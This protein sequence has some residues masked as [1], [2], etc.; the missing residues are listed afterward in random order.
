MCVATRWAVQHFI[1]MI[2][3]IWPRFFIFH[4]SLNEIPIGALTWHLNRCFYNKLI[5]CIYW[6]IYICWATCCTNLFTALCP[7]FHSQWVSP[8]FKPPYFRLQP[9]WAIQVNTVILLSFPNNPLKVNHVGS[10]LIAHTDTAITTHISSFCVFTN[11]G[12][13]FPQYTGLVKLCAVKE[14]P[15]PL[16]CTE[17]LLKRPLSVVLVIYH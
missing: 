1:C 6:S 8:R 10:R 13:L 12:S 17:S 2:K 14:G 7:W 4:I 5:L 15:S 16:I 9:L 3:Q 11:M